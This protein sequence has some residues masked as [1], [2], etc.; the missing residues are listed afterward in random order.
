MTSVIER[1]KKQELWDQAKVV[2]DAE[3]RLPSTKLLWLK[4]I[5]RS[6]VGMCFGMIIL[7]LACIQMTSFAVIIGQEGLRHIQPLQLDNATINACDNEPYSETVLRFNQSKG[8]QLSDLCSNKKSIQHLSIF[9]EEL[10]GNG[11]PHKPETVEDGI[12]SI[13]LSHF[14]MAAC[15]IIPEIRGFIVSLYFVIFRHQEVKNSTKARNVALIVSEVANGAAMAAL[16]FI[17][18]PRLTLFEA[19]I[20]PYMT[21]AGPLIVTLVH[22]SSLHPGGWIGLM[23]D[24]IGLLLLLASIAFIGFEYYWNDILGLDFN[25]ADDYYIIV[26]AV[27]V[28]V[29]GFNSY[30]NYSRL[31]P[32]TKEEGLYWAN[33]IST[34]LRMAIF[35]AALVLTLHQY[36]LETNSAF[37]GNRE[38]QLDETLSVTFFFNERF[39]TPLFGDISVVIDFATIICIV[40][41]VLLSYFSISAVRL[42]YQVLFMVIPIF[43][44]MVLVSSFLFLLPF[45]DHD[46]VNDVTIDRPLG[47]VIFSGVPW[48][49]E[50]VKKRLIVQIR[51]PEFFNFNYLLNI[52]DYG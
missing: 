38:L 3:H 16:T 26:A 25:L 40:T 51:V 50:I 7:T 35:I 33:L 14:A 20:I 45:L 29:Y 46:E 39:N 30:A 18:L 23:L 36:A 19:S 48:E 2:T 22:R 24:I 4:I 34:V 9:M 52:N 5:L 37:V 44:S 21:L 10:I 6:F 28:F 17:V 31:V 32:A 27:A 1:D 15:L 41:S 47:P 8:F 43:I 13:G 49:V 11:R 12:K 42:Q